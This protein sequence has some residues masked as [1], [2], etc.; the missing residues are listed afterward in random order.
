MYA[1]S[2]TFQSNS[3]NKTNFVDGTKWN[4][5]TGSNYEVDIFTIIGQ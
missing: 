2:D 1:G 5:A 3:H 4:H